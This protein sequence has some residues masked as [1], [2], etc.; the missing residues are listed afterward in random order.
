MSRKKRCGHEQQSDKQN[1][2]IVIT[3]KARV[4]PTRYFYQIEVV[5]MHVWIVV[6]MTFGHT[7]A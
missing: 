4:V 2:E 3:T 5:L 6:L 7:H 1:Q